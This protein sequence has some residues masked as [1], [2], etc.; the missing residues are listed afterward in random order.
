MAIIARCWYFTQKI[1]EQS[2]GIE[3]ER[4]L[5]REGM[6]GGDKTMRPFFKLLTNSQE[7]LFSL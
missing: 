2:Y 7:W 3:E 5:R 4:F 1:L 6:R